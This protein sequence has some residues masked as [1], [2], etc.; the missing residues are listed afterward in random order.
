ML[1][2]AGLMIYIIF[3]SVWLAYDGITNA[4]Q[5]TDNLLGDGSFRDVLISVGATY[6]LYLMASLL[7]FDPWHMI[8]SSI[9]YL[10]MTPSYINIL[11]TYAFCN[12]HDVRYRNNNS[13]NSNN[14]TFYSEEVIQYI[15]LLLII[16]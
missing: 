3:A 15:F 1:F 10:L 16:W 7:F 6:A 8:T 13:N 14:D 4:V 9:Q 2:F 5:T 12:T 11:N